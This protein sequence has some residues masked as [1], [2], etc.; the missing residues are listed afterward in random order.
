M[1]RPAAP[2]PLRPVFHSSRRIGG[3][4]VRSCH[5]PGRS[6]RHLPL[7]GTALPRS[8]RTGA[9]G[10]VRPHDDGEIG[11]TRSAKRGEASPRRI[12]G[13][14]YDLQVRPGQA[15]ALL[16]YVQKVWVGDAR[17]SITDVERTLLDGLSRCPNTAVTSPRYSTCSRL[18]M[19]RLDIER[20]AQL[21]LHDSMG[22]PL[23]VWDGPWNTTA[24]LLPS[25]T[26]WRHCR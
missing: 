15:R 14:R 9:Q 26:G 10:G 16:R 1:D 7:V 11:P 3:P 24:P 19:E 2:R 25:S 5:G 4:R 13:R 12:S 8:D 18:G 22:R 6:C 23:S 20:I 21:R 17:V